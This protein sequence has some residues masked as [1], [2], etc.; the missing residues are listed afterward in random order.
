MSVAVRINGFNGR[1]SRFERA[2]LSEIWD[3]LQRI[4]GTLGL[5]TAE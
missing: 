4:K 1:I 5:C 3:L 2:H